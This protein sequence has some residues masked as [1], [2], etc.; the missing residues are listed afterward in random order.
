MSST[1]PECER[2]TREDFYKM[3]E[4]MRYLIM[5]ILGTIF[6]SLAL[7]C[8]K[9]A[10][11]Y[12]REKRSANAQGRPENDA[13]LTCQFYWT[14][15]IMLQALSYVIALFLTISPRYIEVLVNKKSDPFLTKLHL[16][17]YPLQ[18]VLNFLIFAGAKVYHIRRRESGLSLYAALQRILLS[19]S[20]EDTAEAVLLVGISMI[21]A[22][23]GSNIPLEHSDNSNSSITGEPK[24]EDSGWKDVSWNS[25]STT[26]ASLNSDAVSEYDNKRLSSI[27]EERSR[28]SI[29]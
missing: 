18:G 23:Q 6:L 22:E 10:V 20:Y 17:I 15:A 28:V 11:V 13:G 16:A 25:R 27:S 2:G 7:V 1:S 14:R 24:S 26:S 21:D 29:V 3:M 5:V 12:S 19:V 4:Y 9:V 8:I